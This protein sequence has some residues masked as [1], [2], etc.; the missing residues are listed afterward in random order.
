MKAVASEF[1]CGIG[2]LKM[3]VRAEMSTGTVMF[4]HCLAAIEPMSSAS[5]KLESGIILAMAEDQDKVCVTRITS[6]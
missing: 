5:V 6:W 1:D 3:P 2:R 4:W